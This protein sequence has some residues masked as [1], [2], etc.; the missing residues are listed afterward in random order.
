MGKELMHYELNCE[1]PSIKSMSLTWDVDVGMCLD[2]GAF[3]DWI[4]SASSGETIEYHRGFLLCDRSGAN[5]AYDI[6]DQQRISALAR[7][8]WIGA[9]L[10]LLHL[11]SERLGEFLYRYVAV[12]TNTTLRLSV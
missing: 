1:E 9:E 8:A 3:C 2:E 11:Y 7:R 10:G 4:A 6:K 12:R 5:G